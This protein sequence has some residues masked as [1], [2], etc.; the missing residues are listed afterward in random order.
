MIVFLTKNN[1]LIEL[2][3]TA[4]GEADVSSLVKI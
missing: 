1:L 4:A 3:P 2:N